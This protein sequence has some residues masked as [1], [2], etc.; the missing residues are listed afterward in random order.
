MQELAWL[1]E[2]SVDEA[3]TQLPSLK[4]LNSGV[5]RSVADAFLVS[6]QRFAP[7]ALSPRW[8]CFD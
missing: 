8:C 6:L 3:E 1:A 7:W 5:L 4:Q 2:V